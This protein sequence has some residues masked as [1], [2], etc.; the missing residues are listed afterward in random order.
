MAFSLDPGIIRIAADVL[1]KLT[2]LGYSS[3]GWYVL[4]ETIEAT[5]TRGDLS[6]MIQGIVPTTQR[7][8]Q[9]WHDRWVTGIRESKWRTAGATDARQR[10]WRPRGGARAALQAPVHGR[11]V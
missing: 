3:E 6:E 11:G 4:G 8:A 5:R 2:D 9:R 10:C 7:V 1:E